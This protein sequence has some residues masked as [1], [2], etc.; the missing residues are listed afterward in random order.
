[1]KIT[2]R[3]ASSEM[4]RLHW[5]EIVKSLSEMK[6]MA[7]MPEHDGV[8]AKEGC[9]YCRAIESRMAAEVISVREVTEEDALGGE[10]SGKYPLSA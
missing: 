1:M 9:S 6:E 4:Y 7:D 3:E 2:S 8:H 5:P 10:I